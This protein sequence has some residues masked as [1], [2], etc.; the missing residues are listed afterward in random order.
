MSTSQTWAYLFE[1]PDADPSRDRTVLEHP[2]VRAVLVPVPDA[3]AAP[4]AAAGLVDEGVTL[5]ELCGG[6]TPADVAAVRA[7]VPEHVAVGH[8]TFAADSLFAVAAHAR[9]AAQGP[10]GP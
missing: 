3:S 6:M 4:S 2:T 9:A 10:S 7:A 1:H 5:V 8:V